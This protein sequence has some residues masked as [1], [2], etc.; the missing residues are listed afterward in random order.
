MHMH[1][2]IFDCDKTKYMKD[3]FLILLFILNIKALGTI[4]TAQNDTVYFDSPIL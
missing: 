2:V 4:Q 1:F 3:F